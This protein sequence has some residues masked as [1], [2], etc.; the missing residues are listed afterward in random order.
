ML[1][2]KYNGHAIF[3]LVIS[4]KIARETQSKM[5]FAKDFLEI[6]KICSIELLPWIW[7]DTFLK[8]WFSRH[9]MHAIKS[10]IYLFLELIYSTH[11]NNQGLKSFPMPLVKTCQVWLQMSQRKFL[12]RPFPQPY[13][14]PC[15][16]PWDKCKS[17][18]LQAMG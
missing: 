17:I 3:C 2:L 1:T 15:K 11:L 13:K 6:G 5:C 16:Y 18:F 10:R 4:D 9:L 7:L 14:F 8:I 12:A